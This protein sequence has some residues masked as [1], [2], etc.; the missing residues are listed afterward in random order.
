MSTPFLSEIRICS[1]NFAP[2]GWAM[3]NGQLLPINQNQALFSLLGT[4]Y[5]GDGRV[6]FAL[7]NIQGAVAMHQGQGYT[8]GN[9]GGEENHTLTTSELPAH[10]HLVSALPGGGDKFNPLSGYPASSA[11]AQIYSAGGGGA[12]LSSMNPAMVTNAG[13]SQP[14]YNMMPYLVLNFIIALQGI[15]P[16]QN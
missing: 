2:R 14:H 16:S 11:P 12:Q 13:G 8:M 3:C 6:S 4:S 15:Y 9:T 5:G 10:N 1:F 7:P